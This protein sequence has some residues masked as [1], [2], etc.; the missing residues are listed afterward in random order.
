MKE[1]KLVLF[2][3][4]LV[5]AC[6]GVAAYYFVFKPVPVTPTQPLQV[7]ADEPEADPAA[8]KAARDQKLLETARNANLRGDYDTVIESLKPLDE[9]YEVLS[10]LAYA[11]AR[12]GHLETAIVLFERAMTYERMPRDGYALAGLYEQTGDITV[13]MTLYE[14]LSHLNLPENLSRGVLEGLVRTSFFLSENKTAYEASKKLLQRHPDSEIGA[15]TFLRTLP[16]QSESP[17]A[18]VE[19]FERTSGKHFEDNHAVTTWLASFYS[20]VAKQPEKALS[21]Y[22]RALKLDAAV[23]IPHLEIYKIF[24]AKGEH[25]K[26]LEH[27]SAFRTDNPSYSDVFFEASMTALELK[28][29]KNAF[30]LYATAVV[31]KPILL[32]E[33]ER[34]LF[35]AYEKYLKKSGSQLD[36]DFY[37]LF[38]DYINA[39]R[40]TTYDDLVKMYDQL[41]DSPY[42]DIA[43]AIYNERAKEKRADEEHQKKYKAYLKEVAEYE[44]MVKEMEAERKRLE[45][46]SKPSPADLVKIKALNKPHDSKAQYEAAVELSRMGYSNDAKSFL[47]DAARLAP[48][49]YEPRYSLAI[50]ALN[51]GDNLTARNYVNDA[52]A[53]DPS[54]SQ[55]WSLSAALYLDAHENEDAEIAANN[56]IRYNPKNSDAWKILG[57]LS[58][59]KNEFQQ[60]GDYIDRAIA[61]EQNPDKLKELKDL[62]TSIGYY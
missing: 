22:E 47:R 24:T 46:L 58:L 42:V 37:K 50:L 14:V 9:N 26:A 35:I 2:I 11:F 33:S 30:L 31:G 40:E 18:E 48:D 17:L 62:R 23:F 34:G 51:D 15:I 49:A 45:A 6:L 57:Q 60:A 16:E 28:D 61:S 29:I 54:S 12:K 5:I 53:A 41:K 4:V 32:A 3:A 25:K 59:R 8:E 19:L 1:I 36:K 20:E 21:Y 39:K 10:M 43:R 13:A 7:K 38:Y 55:A 27:I 52:L 44:Q 56:A